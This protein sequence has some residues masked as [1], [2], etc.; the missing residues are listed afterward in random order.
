LPRTSS[1]LDLNVAMR[2]G[3]NRGRE[4]GEDFSP[5]LGFRRAGGSGVDVS[6]DAGHPTM[7]EVGVRCRRS[8]QARGCGWQGRALHG[9]TQKVG[10]R[11]SGAVEL[12]G[13]F[14]A[15]WQHRFCVT[16]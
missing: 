2:S 11:V 9:S 1:L 15:A 12:R 10:W 7:K 16:G 6:G 3:S 8:R 14:R 13:R 4:R 5:A